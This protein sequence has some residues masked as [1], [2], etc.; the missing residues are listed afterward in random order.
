MFNHYLN[1][2][3]GSFNLNYCL[4][5]AMC[6]LSVLWFFFFCCFALFCFF[7]PQRKSDP[8][9][10]IKSSIS[11]VW[12]GGYTRDPQLSFTEL[13]GLTWLFRLIIF[14]FF[15][16]LAM[17]THLLFLFNGSSLWSQ[18]NSLWKKTGIHSALKQHF[19][20]GLYAWREVSHF[21]F[22]AL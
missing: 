9:F 20:L 17:E 11:F 14:T 22:F 4:H 3:A 6:G 19:S 15:M 8:H 12:A 1:Q 18:L 7:S 13:Q 2:Q 5:F 10:L 16:M 21:F